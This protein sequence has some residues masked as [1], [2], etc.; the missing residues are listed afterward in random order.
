MSGTR[1]SVPQS[2]G[3]FSSNLNVHRANHHSH[4]EEVIRVVS[5]VMQCTPEE[6]W[7]ELL[8]TLFYE[9][10]EYHHVDGK[11]VRK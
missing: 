11:K 2:A 8:K 7:R 4:P 3:F 6:E 5:R 1:T 9:M 10:P